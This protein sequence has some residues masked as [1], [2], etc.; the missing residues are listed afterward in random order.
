M[1]LNKLSDFLFSKKID[2]ITPI[3]FITLLIIIIFSYGISLIFPDT[4]A[5]MVVYPSLGV[6]V[7]VLLMYGIAYWPAIFFGTL[8]SLLMQGD[9]FLLALFLAIA[10]SI[11]AILGVYLV[12]RKTNL[13]YS[14]QT[15]KGYFK[16]FFIV[17]F[18]STFVGALLYTTIFYIFNIIQISQLVSGLEFIWMG[19]ILGVIV[20]TPFILIWKQKTNYFIKNNIFEI[21]LVFGVSLFA[22]LVIFLDWAH[23][24]LGAINRGYWMYLFV[25]IAAIRFGRHGASLVI[26]MV[27]IFGVMGAYEG[28]GFFSTDI[29]NTGLTNYWVYIMVIVVVGMVQATFIK[30]LRHKDKMLI[31]QSRHAAMGEMIGMIAHQWRQPISTNIDGC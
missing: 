19:H 15:S 31:N 12:S 30:E 20:L 28:T 5:V 27:S 9:S 13:D 7:A 29:Y 4:T 6:G 8:L 21:F 2:I 25:S 23:L 10:T 11:E 14:L 26:M 1:N 16:F 18:F 24:Y 3:F 17:G 22:S